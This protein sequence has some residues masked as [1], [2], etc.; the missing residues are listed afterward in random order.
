[1]RLLDAGPQ[2]LAT[3]G[4]RLYERRH[5]RQHQGARASRSGSRPTSACSCKRVGR[6]DNRPLLAAGD[7]EKVMKKLMAERYPDLCRG[8]RHGREPRR[9]PRGDR[10][11]GG[12]CDRRQAR[13]QRAA[14]QGRL[15]QEG[16]NDARRRDRPGPEPRARRPSRS[17]F[18]DGATPSSSA[19]ICSLRRAQR[20]AAALPGARCAVVSDANVAALYLAPLKASLDRQGL[21]LGEVVVAPG[22]ASKSFPVLARRLRAACSSSASSAATASLRLAAAWSA[23]SP[24]LP[25]A[26]C[27]AASAW[28]RCRP[29][30]SPR[31]IPR[32][33]AR[34]ASTPRKAR[35]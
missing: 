3:G 27:G 32:S 5:A 15:L 10:R 21:L 16:V 34:P 26:S 9:A 19:S 18:P 33:A 24:A 30:C 17:S 8:R 35:T 4:G 2:V 23:I 6:R 22:E 11:R 29:R 28:C 25:P 13:M 7:P 12:R 1:M 20:I 14:S 31:S